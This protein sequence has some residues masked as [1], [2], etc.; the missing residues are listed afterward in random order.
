MGPSMCLGTVLQMLWV[1]VVEDNCK[2]AHFS[3]CLYSPV[4]R[5]LCF[6]THRLQG[7]IFSLAMAV[8]A[9]SQCL[10]QLAMCAGALLTGAVLKISGEGGQAQG[11][12]PQGVEHQET[13]NA[14]QA[15]LAQSVHP[16]QASPEESDAEENSA[17]KTIVGAVMQ[18]LLSKDMLY[19][20]MKDICLRYPAWFEAHEAGLDPAEMERFRKQYE[21]M[22]QII[23]LYE[24][25]PDNTIELMSLM[26]QVQQYGQPP[27]EIV[28][29]V[30]PSEDLTGMFQG[31][32]PGFVPPADLPEMPED[33]K[34]Q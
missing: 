8:C 23:E 3:L 14:L 15:A 17:L 9:V 4:T 13:L 5:Q 27:Q 11:P 25:D 7:C 29:Q 1:A 32:A 31:C 30:A 12:W 19:E 21:Y 34:M 18:K 20:P 2:I 6:A 28:D 10:A 33:C 22:Q 16:G 24:R 26:Q